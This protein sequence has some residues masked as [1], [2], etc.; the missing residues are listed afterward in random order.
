MTWSY[1]V[2]PLATSALNQVRLLIG[3]TLSTDEQLQDEEIQFFIDN[4]QSTYMAA[5]RSALAIAAEYSR[6]VDKEMGDLKILA[7]Q[8]HRHYLELA[9]Q[10]RLKNVPAILSAGGV[11]Q[12]EKDTLSD[13][14]DWVQPW[15]SRG[16]MDNS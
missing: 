10:L 11:W 12:S 1:S 7:A 8:R 9:E 5:Y 13:N 16:M 3:D 6:K 15:F 14:A 4:E 2:S